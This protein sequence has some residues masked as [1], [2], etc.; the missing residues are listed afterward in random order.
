M[1]TK[2]K[3]II[4]GL[5]IFVL[6]GLTFSYGLSSYIQNQAMSM[7]ESE[8]SIED[9]IITFHQISTSDLKSKELVTP[10]EKAKNLILLIADGMSLSQVTAYRL[11]NG[12]PNHRIALD[13]F[14][15]TG[16]VL[17]H[18]TDA[19]ITDSA[20]SATAFSTGQ[21]TKNGALGVDPENKNIE[22]LTETLDKYGFVS[23]LI[24]TSEITH[25]TPAAFASHV[26]SR[27]NSDEISKQMV[28]ES[29]VTTFLA[30]GRNFFTPEESGGIRKDGINLLEEVKSSHIFLSH[31]DEL[32][33]FDLG[34]SGKVFGLF[35]DEALR[36]QET[37]ENHITEPEMK[38]MLDFA[39]SRS[40]NYMNKGCKGFFI[41]AEGSQVDWAGHANN[42]GYLNREMAD[43][44][45]AVEWALQY[46]KDNKDTLVVV[47]ADHETGGLLIEPKTLF[48]YTGD[49]IKISFNTS[50]GFGSHTGVPVPVYAYGP[51][52]ENFSGTLDN[53]DLYRAMVAALDLENE[54][55]SCVN[56]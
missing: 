32:S 13:K 3:K 44:D 6:G 26:E 41:M 55:P 22:N 42:I 14:P 30:G 20:S 2:L 54:Q 21:K 46:A 8:G 27:R 9:K 16:I 4:I 5:V 19:F 37:P 18:S 33:N 43:F 24:A 53:T 31:K 50:K 34:Q 15:T 48:G 39:V 35:A 23:S 52:S 17:T 56:N 51:G 29:V 1:N 11:L 40:E 10:K 12:G 36:Q 38:Q 47:T 28:N 7:V 25:A 45:T 49:E